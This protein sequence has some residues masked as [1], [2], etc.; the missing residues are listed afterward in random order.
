MDGEEGGQAAEVMAGERRPCNRGAA[1]PIS[2]VPNA[3][4]Y[5]LWSLSYQIPHVFHCTAPCGLNLVF[6]ILAARDLPLPA[7]P[8]LIIASLSGR[9]P[10]Q[11]DIEFAQ[12][13]SLRVDDLT[14]A[15]NL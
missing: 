5:H 14:G 15:G 6:L 8:R 4:P 2:Q 10:A 11:I 7:I 12:R 3:H 9:R 1:T 13:Y